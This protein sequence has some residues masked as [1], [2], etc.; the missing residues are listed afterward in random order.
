MSGYSPIP[1]TNLFTSTNSTSVKVPS[2]FRSIFLAKGI[3][4]KHLYKL[5]PAPYNS[6]CHDSSSPGARC[7]LVL[8]SQHH[9]EKTLHLLLVNFPTVVSIISKVTMFK[10]RLVLFLHSKCPG[11]LVRDFLREDE[12][13]DHDKFSEVHI[14]ITIRVKG[15][16]IYFFFYFIC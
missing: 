1:L 10:A 9:G 4:Y 12:L 6:F 14:A 15:P 7:G 3:L 5:M 13:V 2:P 11:Q 16:E 8:K